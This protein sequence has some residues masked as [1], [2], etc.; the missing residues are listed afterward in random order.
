MSATGFGWSCLIPAETSR[1][2]PWGPQRPL[3]FP[4][5]STWRGAKD[6]AFGVTSFLDARTRPRASV[7]MLA[8]HGTAF[9][10]PEF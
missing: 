3:E 7:G 10:I 5:T 9:P 6:L 8:I 1:K 4:T 2:D